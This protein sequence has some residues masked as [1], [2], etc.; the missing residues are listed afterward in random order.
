[1]KN[2]YSTK[3]KCHLILLVA[4]LTVPVLANAQEWQRF[5]DGDEFFAVNFP[6]E[7][8][9]AD[10]LYASEYG[11]QLPA[12]TYSLT[13]NEVDYRVTV[14]NYGTDEKSYV[15]L[16]DHTEDQEKERESQKIDDGRHIQGQN[17]FGY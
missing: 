13:A 6:G 5:V 17:H 14:V 12:R 16:D 11:G 15:R 4:A 8:E 2:V 1:M 3:S 7:P 10:F 9:V